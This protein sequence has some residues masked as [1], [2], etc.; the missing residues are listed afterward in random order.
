MIFIEICQTL[1]I[2]AYCYLWQSKFIG[3]RIRVKGH[4]I[5]IVKFIFIAWYLGPKFKKIVIFWE[6]DFFSYFL[7]KKNLKQ[8]QIKNRL[9]YGIKLVEENILSNFGSYSIYRFQ[10]VSRTGQKSTLPEK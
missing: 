4:L 3:E 10:M 1:Y 7:R 2:L 5:C 9:Y 8:M 6:K